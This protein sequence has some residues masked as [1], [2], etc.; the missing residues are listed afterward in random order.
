MQTGKDQYGFGD[1][2]SSMQS[3][4]SEGLGSNTDNLPHYDKAH[5]S[6]VKLLSYG[7]IGFAFCMELIIIM[8]LLMLMLT[9]LMTIMMMMVG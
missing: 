5:S 6:N 8:M 1:F 7:S 2:S 4:L 9:L 3:S